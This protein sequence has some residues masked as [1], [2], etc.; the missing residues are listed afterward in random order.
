MLKRKIFQERC[1]DGTVQLQKTMF[2]IANILFNILRNLNLIITVRTI[3]RPLF[4][5]TLQ[6]NRI[7]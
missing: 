5:Q 1:F 7:K 4:I 3:I 6:R 2:Y